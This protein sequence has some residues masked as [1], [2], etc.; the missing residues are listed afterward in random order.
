MD[1]LGGKNRVQHARRKAR[2]VGMGWELGKRRQRHGTASASNGIPYGHVPPMIGHD[3]LDR[4]RR[5]AQRYPQQQHHTEQNTKQKWQNQSK[6]NKQ[7]CI[8][9]RAS[10]PAS[11]PWLL[12]T[13]HHRP[14][15]PK[16]RCVVTITLIHH[17][18]ST[19]RRAAPSD[20]SSSPPPA[21]LPTSPNVSTFSQRAAAC[22]LGRRN[23]MPPPSVPP[24]RQMERRNL[25]VTKPTP[26]N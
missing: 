13:A 1:T 12:A 26:T 15:P 16:K 3:D 18:A 22:M 2:R 10:I 14:P 5:R 23:T 11:E 19:C 6:M 8:S 17:I 20:L 4:E 24:V 21:I 7:P 25:L 9:L